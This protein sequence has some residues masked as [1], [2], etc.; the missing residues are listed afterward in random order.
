M[1][2]QGTP[3]S[4]GIAVGSA[5][6]LHH[7]PVKVEHRYLDEP[8]RADEVAAYRA[9]VE[10]A[11]ERLTEIYERYRW[12]G[13]KQ[14]E[15]FQA[16]LDILHDIQLNDEIEA[17]ILNEGKLAPWAVSSVYESYMAIFSEMEDPLLRE[18]A[19]DLNDVSD[20]LIRILTG[21][22]S[23]TSL[24]ELPEGVILVA[25][26]L[27]PS[28]TV[29][30][31]ANIVHGIVTEAGGMTSHTAILARS[32]GIPAVLGLPGIMNAVTNGTSLI[33]DGSEG[34]VLTQPTAEQTAFYRKEREKFLRH[35]QLEEQ[36]LPQQAVT[37]DAMRIGIHLNISS[38]SITPYQNVL[39]YV[40]GAGLFRSEFLYLNRS[41]LPTEEEQ[42]TIYSNTLRAFG[43]RPVVLRTLDIGGDKKTDC[44]PIPQEDN[45]FLGLRAIRLCF[46]QPELFYTQLRAAYRAAV[47][48]NLFI[49]FPMVNSVEDIRKA[50]AFCAEV[51]EELEK[52]GIPYGKGVKLGVMIETP[53][54]ALMAEEVAREVDFASIGTNDLCQYTLATDRLNSAV[55]SYFRPYHPAILRLIAH[56]AEAFQR[57]N[58]PLSLC[59]EMGG[60]AEVIP[61]LLGLGIHKLSMSS[62]CVAAAKAA[63]CRTDY[64]HCQAIAS[65]A[66]QAVTEDE[67]RKI[68]RE[69]I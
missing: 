1:R 37:S 9:A 51:Q 66:L 20:R 63:T 46:A 28:Q 2:Y 60:N 6:C 38:A 56:T 14:A 8:L 39:P 24:A 47:H 12:K 7:E 64:R 22:A 52:E 27:M 21:A 29:S 58:K 17:A 33:M 41:K 13:E 53:A 26:D 30:L 35:Q 69:G 44:I 50:K 32:L 40:D 45:P 68:M 19:A 15:I 3:A 5:Y 34:I 54:I 11:D 23:A 67:V 43:E 61:L 57:Y 49:M 18:R 55:G 4:K 65:L 25:H 48:G 10:Q 59:G 42:Y 16:H 36:F 31:T 62:S